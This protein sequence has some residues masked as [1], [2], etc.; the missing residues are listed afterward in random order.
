MTLNKSYDVNRNEQLGNLDKTS[1]VF[2]TN[3]MENAIMLDEIPINYGGY[4]TKVFA[5]VQKRKID[6]CVV[7]SNSINGFGRISQRSIE[8]KQFV[9]DESERGFFSR[10]RK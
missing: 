4:I 5:T 6:H 9:K 1:Y 7:M 3:R 2:L 10:F 8:M